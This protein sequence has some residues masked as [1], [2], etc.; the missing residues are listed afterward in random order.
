MESPRCR[1]AMKVFA[2]ILDQEVI[3]RILHNIGEETTPPRVLPARSPPQLEMDFARATCPVTW[4][5]VNRNGTTT[6]P[7]PH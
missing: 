5:A 7:R 6:S 3:E 1:Q 2:F 4:D